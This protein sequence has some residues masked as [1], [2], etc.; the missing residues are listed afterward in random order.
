MIDNCTECGKE[1][2][3]KHLIPEYLPE[4]NSGK[5][6]SVWFCSPCLVKINNDIE[7]K[8]SYMLAPG[9]KNFSYRP[10]DLIRDICYFFKITEQEILKKSRERRVVVPRQVLVYFLKMKFGTQYNLTQI[11]HFVGKDDHSLMIHYIKMV[12]N[13]IDS[14]KGYRKMIEDLSKIIESHIINQN[15]V[16]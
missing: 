10:E 14:D 7:G 4:I 6:G 15:S 9:V 1:F 2:E 13:D 11:S 3:I 8:P 12:N 16:A 5:G